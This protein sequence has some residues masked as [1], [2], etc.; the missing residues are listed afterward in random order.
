VAENQGRI[1]GFIYFYPQADFQTSEVQ[2]YIA[3]FG[4][5]RD[6]EGQGVG[7]ALLAEVESWCMSRGYRILALDVFAMN[8]AARAYYARRGFQ[9]QTLK[10]VKV[11]EGS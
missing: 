10:L 2:G 9:E 3:D 11:L 8:M 1:L 5:D 7:Q 6:Q 4:V